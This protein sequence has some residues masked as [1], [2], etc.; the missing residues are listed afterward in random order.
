MPALPATSPFRLGL[1]GGIGS[2]K[3][4]VAL[5]LQ[6]RGATLI[7]ADH[8]SRSLTAVGGTA[9]PSI[10]Q[11]FG[12]DIIDTQGALNRARM[13]ELVFADP[14]AR[15]KL[16]GIIHPLIA[17]QTRLQHEAAITAGSKLIVHDIPLLVESSHWRSKLDGVL[18]VDCRESTQIE[19]V[20]ARSGLS[21]DT[22]QNIIAAQATRA[23]RLAAADWVLY[24]DEGITIDSLSAYTDQIATWFGL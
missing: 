24:N 10:A 2:G 20:I 9:L 21:A 23:Q 13:R 7:D 17:E 22:V 19:R 18:V 3:S 11:A 8:I 15:Q 14:Q 4:T 5:R 1:T 6:E 16:E 12:S